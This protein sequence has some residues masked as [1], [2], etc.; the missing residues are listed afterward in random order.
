[1]L[2]QYMYIVTFVPVPPQ[3]AVNSLNF[4]FWVNIRM[5]LKM[6]IWHFTFTLVVTLHLGPLRSTD[7]AGLEPRK[8]MHRRDTLQPK[9]GVTLLLICGRRTH[10]ELHICTTHL[11]IADFS[12]LPNSTSSGN[13]SF[14]PRR[15]WSSSA[16]A[17]SSSS[18]DESSE[19]EEEELPS[20]VDWDLLLLLEEWLWCEVDSLLSELVGSWRS[21]WTLPCKYQDEN[22]HN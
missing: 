11:Y 17:T 18:S 15:P 20:V 19:L 5:N 12:T 8:H 4:Q 6:T 14:N 7:Y 21:C 1:M 16:T 13:V 2:T 3:W 10:L 22:S 9:I